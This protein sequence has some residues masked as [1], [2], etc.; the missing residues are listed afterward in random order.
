MR[1]CSLVF[2]L[3]VALLLGAASLAR[4]AGTTGADFLQLEIPANA[5]ALAAGVAGE[6]G[7]HSLTWN[8]AGILGQKS[9]SVSFTHVAS[10]VDTAYEQLEG[11][12]PG[13]L[14]GSWALQIFYA[15][16]YNFV[17]FNEYGEEVG[18]LENY[19]LVGTVAYARPL[20]AD[21]RAG[22]ALKV[23][24][25]VLAGFSSQGLVADLGLQYRLA[26]GPL[27]VGVA[28]RN[29]GGMTAYE[30]EADPLPACLLAG[31]ALNLSPWPGHTVSLLSDWRRPLAAPEDSGVAVGLAYT[32]HELVFVRSGYRLLN[33][34]GSLSLG[35][36]V[37]HAAFGL[38][39]AFQP[40]AELGDNH[41]FTLTY[42]FL[43]AEDAR[44]R[45]LRSEPL[46]RDALP[47]K[48][49][50]ANVTQAK[51]KTLT[52]LPRNFEGRLFFKPPRLA[53]QVKAWRFEIR[54][55]SGRVVR[56]FAGDGAPPKTLSWDGRDASGALVRQAKNYQYIFQAG[57]TVRKQSIPR[58]EPPLKLRFEDG[59]GIEP[60]VRFEFV[61]RPE[62]SAWTLTI[63]ERETRKVVRN[64]TGKQA[65]PKEIMW[66]GKD[67][68]GAVADTCLTYGYDLAIV[69]PDQTEIVVS[70][71][72]Q[73]ILA[74]EVKAP[75]GKTGVVIPG[76]LFDFNSAVL[77]SARH[78]KCRAAGELIRRHPRHAQVICE[79]HAD[80]IG[81][82]AANLKLSQARALMVAN[83]LAKSQPS[84]RDLIELVGFGQDRPENRRGNED[85]RA[86]NRRVEI[87][88]ILPEK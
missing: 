55:Q 74:R 36:G 87:H 29:L 49:K 64:L 86:R 78:D 45:E 52:V 44:P 14:E 65:L 40:F 17:E 4:A 79:G 7:S 35:A 13:W 80:E 60:A 30:E 24:N 18:N 26:G 47:M 1:R 12:Y 66:D 6:D 81:S 84:S 61:D 71:D 43:P 20:G 76:I 85:G 22:V 68:T 58:L 15:T 51:P 2:N 63:R 42:Y 19:D 62:V 33:D 50:V 16:T 10:F 82:Q 73:A 48:L 59:A 3:A 41:R 23:F 25:S 53:P 56:A 34:L 75:E 77:D 28:L 72:I 11:L 8:P 46:G 57:K 37:R 83:F 54:D 69:Y 39:Y 21:F 38:D 88:L 70:E 5:A 32:Y 27:R 67:E 31:L 9:P